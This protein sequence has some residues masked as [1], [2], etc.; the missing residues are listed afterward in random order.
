MSTTPN[1]VLLGDPNDDGGTLYWSNTEGWVDAESATVFSE[2][3]VE[4][5][6]EPQGS[7][8][9]LVV[10]PQDSYGSPSVRS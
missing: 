4:A 2:D 5:F 6:N 10:R 9:W 1:Y 8:G 7:Y 3:E